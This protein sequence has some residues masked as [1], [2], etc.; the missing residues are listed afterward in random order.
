MFE[1]KDVGFRPGE[2]TG[3][4]KGSAARAHGPQAPIRTFTAAAPLG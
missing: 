2:N 1:G 3:K 4:E